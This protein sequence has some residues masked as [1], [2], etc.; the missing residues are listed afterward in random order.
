MPPR[1]R[2]PQRASAQAAHSQLANRQTVAVQ[3]NY[4]PVQCRLQATDFRRGD[5]FL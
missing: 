4:V 5:C 1:Q 2:L 3:T